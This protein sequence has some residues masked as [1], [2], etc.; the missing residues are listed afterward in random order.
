[1]D[2]DNHAVRSDFLIIPIM[3]IGYQVNK[4]YAVRMTTRSEQF[5]F[6]SSHMGESLW[7]ADTVELSQHQAQRKC[8]TGHGAI[9]TSNSAEVLYG[10]GAIATSNSAEVLFRSWGYRNIKVRGS[11]IQVMGLSQHQTQRKCYTGRGAIATSNSAEVLYGHGAI[12]TS[13]SAEM[14]YRSWSCNIKLSGHSIQIVELGNT[15]F[16]GNAVQI[17]ELQ[18]Q[19]QRTFYTD[20]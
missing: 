20:R 3:I 11:A 13:N 12:A 2:T 18:H 16:S 5:P 1:M 9:A 6:H 8:Y 7:V 17:V 15:K 10:H 14:L 19:T 4:L